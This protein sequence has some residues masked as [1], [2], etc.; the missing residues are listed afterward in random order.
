[1][2]KSEIK[3]RVNIFTLLTVFL[4]LTTLV[5][6]VSA[7]QVDLNG[8]AYSREI[9]RAADL[10]TGIGTNGDAV[11]AARF[12]MQSS[13][14]WALRLASRLPFWGRLAITAGFVLLSYLALRCLVRLLLIAQKQ[15]HHQ[16]RKIR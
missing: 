15:Q 4:A 8:L 11:Q 12:A 2:K 3:N 5:W 16:H 1:M 6:V 13:N 7:L 14:F 10:A 9:S